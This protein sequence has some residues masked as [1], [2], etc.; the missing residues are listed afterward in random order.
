MQSFTASHRQT[1]AQP[2]P[3]LTYPT[4]L[5][6]IAEHDTPWHGIAL[7]LAGVTCLVVSLPKFCAPYSLFAVRAE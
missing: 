2:V 1:D 6:F 3:K 4:P 5:C 7:C